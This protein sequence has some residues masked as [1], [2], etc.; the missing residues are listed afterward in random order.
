M[1]ISYEWSSAI[2]AAARAKGDVNDEYRSHTSAFNGPVCRV[3]IDLGDDAEDADHFV[4]P[5]ERWRMAVSLRQ[6]LP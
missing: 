5:E 1:I 2:T 4:S 3:R 6:Q